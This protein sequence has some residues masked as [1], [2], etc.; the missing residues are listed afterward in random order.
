MQLADGP[1]GM[2][3]A[4]LKLFLLPD[5]RYDAC[6]WVIAATFGEVM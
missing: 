5:A 3:P 1:Y 6:D 2:E 4:R